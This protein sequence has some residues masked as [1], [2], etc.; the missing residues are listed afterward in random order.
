MIRVWA[1]TAKIELRMDHGS[2]QNKVSGFRLLCSLSP[3]L[4]SRADSGPMASEAD[5]E[6]QLAAGFLEFRL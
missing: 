6:P 2:R 3:S 1:R 5:G 4:G